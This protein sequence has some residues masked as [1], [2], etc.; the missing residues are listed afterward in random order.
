MNINPIITK[1]KPGDE[2]CILGY[3]GSYLSLIFESLTALKYSGEIKI[4]INEAEKRAVA[5][6]ETNIPYSEIF[7]TE[8][9]EAPGK[10]YIFC[11]NKPSTKK[12]LFEFYRKLWKTNQSEFFNLI[13]P[14]SVISSTV[15][16]DTGVQIEPLSVVAPYTKFEFG[17]NVGRNCSVGHHNILG[18]YCSIYL[19]TNIAGYVEIGEGTTIGPGCT[20]FSNIKIGSN[21]II[22]GGSVV[23]KDIPSNVLAFGNPCQIVKNLS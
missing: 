12:F 13:H 22:G 8:L 2:V 3:S 15:T 9:N 10:G 14:S 6:F 20:V 4:I 23:T 5:P 16:T 17:V 21:T 19:G 11:S 7:Y 1:I 18:D